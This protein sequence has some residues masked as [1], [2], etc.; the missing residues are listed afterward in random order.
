MFTRLLI[1]HRGEPFG[2]AE[3][4]AKPKRRVRKAHDGDLDPMEHRH[5]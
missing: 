2:K 3:G 4:S 1:A 5:V